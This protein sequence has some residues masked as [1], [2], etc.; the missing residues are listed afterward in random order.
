M[1]SQVKLALFLIAFIL[2]LGSSALGQDQACSQP[3]GCGSSPIII[4]LH[5]DNQSKQV[6]LTDAASGV[7]F[8]IYGNGHPVRA[9]WIAD[10]SAAFLAVDRDGDGKITS[11]KELFG[12]STDQNHNGFLALDDYTGHAKIDATNPKWNTL[13]LWT[14]LN[15]NGI[16]EPGELQ[17]VSNVLKR[18]STGAIYTGKK[19][20]FGNLYEYQGRAW[21]LDKPDP[22][23]IYDVTLL[24]LPK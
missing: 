7:D 3:N 14:D 15:H 11:G 23:P 20:P 18:I 22:R 8:D 16:S 4:P 19:D 5:V 24:T 13:L 2:S 1:V 6:Q 21:Y 10:D 9:A 17:P 12:D